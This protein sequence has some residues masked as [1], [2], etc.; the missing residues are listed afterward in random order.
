MFQQ[1]PSATPAR[2][3]STRSGVG[4]PREPNPSNPDGR[5]RAGDYV[6]GAARIRAAA[7]ASP[8]DLLNG[9]DRD[10]AN[11]WLEAATRP[12]EVKLPAVLGGELMPIRE[13]ATFSDAAPKGV[14]DLV[15]LKNTVADPN[16]ITADASRERIHSRT[17]LAHWSLDWTSPTRSRRR[18]ALR[19]CSFISL[20]PTIGP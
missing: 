14:N 4:R 17:R 19:R 5:R 20:P 13:E 3:Q 10:F 1:F 2:L 11:G 7:A 16:Y 8:G 9:P 18:T 6:L 12:L 15:A